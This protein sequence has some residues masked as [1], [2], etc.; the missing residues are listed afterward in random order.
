MFTNAVIRSAHITQA[1]V[2]GLADWLEAYAKSM[3]LDIWMSAN[4]VSAK[5]EDSGKWAVTVQRGD[6]NRV[7]H[8]DHV[9]FALGIGGGVPQMPKIPGMVCSE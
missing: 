4:V 5:L 2:E 3:E 1:I 7:L 6:K 8:V 9:I